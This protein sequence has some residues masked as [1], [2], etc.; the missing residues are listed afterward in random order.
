MNDHDDDDDESMYNIPKMVVERRYPLTVRYTV[1]S[2]HFN[3]ARQK[4]L[5]AVVVVVVMARVV[6]MVASSSSSFHLLFLPIF[7]PPQ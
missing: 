2:I 3:I 1:V 6:V 5:P 7:A 4:A